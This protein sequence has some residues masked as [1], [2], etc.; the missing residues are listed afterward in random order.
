MYLGIDV[1]GTKTL[2]ASFTDAGGIQERVKFLTPRSYDVFAGLLAKTVEKL[3]TKVFTA[4]TV[5]VPGR[6]D[7][8]AGVGIAMG[9]LPWRQV[10]IRQDVQKL[11]QCPVIVDNDANLAGLSEA[12]LV[13]NTYSRVLYVTIGTGIGTG[14]IT[15]QQI[16]PLYA[17]AEGGL[18]LLEH[19]GKLVKWESFASGKAIKERYGKFAE[20][21][22]DETSWRE[23]AYNIALGLIDL[24]AVVQPE[25]IIFGGGVATYFAR[26]KTF[27]EEN[28][29]TYATP[30]TPMPPI[31]AAARPEDAVVYGC[32]ELAKG[33][34]GRPLA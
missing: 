9:N 19:G 30:L 17:D 22:T 6:V 18:M 34:Y 15:N 33:I 29:E 16:D 24:I 27:L 1:G 8:A 26:F 14:I 12:T 11:L 7:R 23:I 2:V 10:P 13:K 20:D 32:Y 5:A 21:I 4:C 3:S 31:C 28:L 25:V